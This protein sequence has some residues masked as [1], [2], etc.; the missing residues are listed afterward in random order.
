[1]CYI[2]FKYLLDEG[3]VEGVLALDFVTTVKDL[4][5]DLYSSKQDLIDAV[6]SMNI[7][8]SDEFVKELT[9]KFETVSVMLESFET[10]YKKNQSESLNS[11]KTALESV[12]ASLS[13]LVSFVKET[14]SKNEW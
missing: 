13:N 2:I 10:E 9:D 14:N 1:M 4:R 7:V 8:T 6:N 11:I 12:S 5:V 3:L